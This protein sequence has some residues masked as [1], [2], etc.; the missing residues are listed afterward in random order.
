MSWCNVNVIGYQQALFIWVLNQ[1]WG[2]DIYVIDLA[3]DP[4]WGNIG[5]V[6]FF[7]QSNTGAVRKKITIN[8]TAKTLLN[9]FFLKL[10]EAMQAR[11]RPSE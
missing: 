7:F 8:I 3:W 6:F 11:Y 4:Y 2:Q 5:G 1:E 10:S 9:A